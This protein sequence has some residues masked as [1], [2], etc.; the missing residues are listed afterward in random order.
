M[1]LTPADPTT[2]IEIAKLVAI[3]A[4]ISAVAV[5]AVSIVAL[6]RAPDAVTDSVKA[7]VGAGSIIRLITILAIVAALVILGCLGMVSGD[8]V[9]AALSGIAGYVL[10]GERLTPSRRED[11]TGAS[12]SK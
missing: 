7:L 1:S 12:N 3:V 2:F 6:L 8:A 10:G 5:A 11:H 4:G 9:V